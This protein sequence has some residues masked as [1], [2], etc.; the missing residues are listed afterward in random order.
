VIQTIVTIL[1]LGYITMVVL[2]GILVAV[3]WVLKNFFD[4]SIDH[5]IDNIFGEE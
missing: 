2:G 4:T 5:W 1:V 3:D